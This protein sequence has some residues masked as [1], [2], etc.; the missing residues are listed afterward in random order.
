MAAA[1]RAE[2]PRL[3]T[4]GLGDR[5]MIV[6]RRASFGTLLAA[7][8]LAV[9][10][11]ACTASA[12]DGPN[13]KTIA[14]VIPVGNRV[15]TPDQIRSMMHSRPGIAYEEA[16]VQE[17]VR[18]LHGTKWFTPG[19]VQILTKSEPDGRVTILVHVTELTNTVQDVQFKGAQHN[20]SDLKTLCGVRKGEPMNPLANELGR[21]AIQRKYQD[22]GRYYAT[23]E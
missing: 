2:I 6:C 20:V 13:G 23:V 16:V 8:F 11:L 3:P 1:T 5:P 21:Q 18:R 4:R 22:D 15:R 17:D 12:A 7:A 9:V 10:A 19:G 14:E